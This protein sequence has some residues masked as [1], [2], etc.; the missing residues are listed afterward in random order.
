MS[1]R[2]KQIHEARKRGITVRQMKDGAM[3]KIN[4]TLASPDQKARLKAI[5]EEHGESAYRAALARVGI[6]R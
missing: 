3:F 2:T 1:K 6:K 5:R 4:R